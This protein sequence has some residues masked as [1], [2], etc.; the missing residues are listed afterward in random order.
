MYFACFCVKSFN[1][2]HIASKCR[3]KDQLGPNSGPIN[4]QDLGLFLDYFQ[5]FLTS[6][7]LD[8]KKNEDGGQSL[9]LTLKINVGYG[10]IPYIDYSF[11]IQLC[12]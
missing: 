3:I 4:G 11:L 6:F 10:S 8:T 7:F 2:P 9:N 1:M 12:T 5:T